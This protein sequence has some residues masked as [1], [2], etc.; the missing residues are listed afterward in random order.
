MPSAY[1]VIATLSRSVAKRRKAAWSGSR[2][3]A[4]RYSAAGLGLFGSPPMSR[5]SAREGGRVLALL[6]RKRSA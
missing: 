2:G 3:K 5:T 1:A 4:A 6:V